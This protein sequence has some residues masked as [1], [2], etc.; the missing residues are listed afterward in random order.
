MWVSADV[1]RCHGQQ[2][3]RE[4]FL[5]AMDP[6]KTWTVSEI[7]RLVRDVLEQSFYPFWIAGEVSNLTIHRS[8][9][10]YFS[11]K[12]AQSQV[13]A[14]FF[15]GA[16]QARDAGLESGMAIE[17]HGR[18]SV[19]EPRGEYQVIVERLRTKGKGDLQRRFEELKSAL[20]DEG[21]FDEDRK[22]PIPALPARIGVV[23]SPQGAAVRD[24]LQILHRRFANVQVRVVP[25]AVQG[26][27]AA[28]EIAAAVAWLNREDAC[29]V[30]VVTRGGGSLEDL[31]PF[32]EEIVARAI[33]ASRLPVISAVGHEVDFTIADFVADLRV[34]TPSAAAE[35]VIGRKSELVERIAGC[36]ERLQTI[37]RFRLSELR[38]RLE[39]S[40]GSY[41]FQEPRRLVERH[42]QRVD[43]LSLRLGRVIE[44]DF[45]QRRA[46]LERLTAQLGSMNPRRVLARGYAILTQ[47]T[48]GAA[49]TD[50][51]TVGCG[52]RLR[53]RLA[54][55]DLDLEVCETFL[56]SPTG[57]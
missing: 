11:L 16:S 20:R 45:V 13:R 46:R 44:G 38:R 36:R 29:D 54:A 37:L 42:Q 57:G 49:V 15:R 2:I 9:H 27:G 21:L 4:G 18:L 7:N 5:A 23:T 10:V 14:V 55:G 28:K 40:A 48:T 19:Y 53:A 30:I 50:A 35:L 8:G 51:A 41:V 56:E 25:V 31:W 32:N 24:F 33:A 52:D 6:A 39:R 34:A 47:A 22:R 43:E 3:P 26:A 1:G 12:D 17:V